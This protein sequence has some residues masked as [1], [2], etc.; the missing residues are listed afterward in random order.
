M[1]QFNLLVQRWIPVRRLSNKIDLIAP[2][3][4]VEGDDPPMRI[5]APRPD[6]DGALLQFLI[7][8]LQTVVA[9]KSRKEWADRYD[10]RFEPSVLRGCFEAFLQVFNLD[11]PGPRFMQD[12]DLKPEAAEESLIGSLLIDMPGEQG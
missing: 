2:W 9:P 1:Q 5:E 8:L 3:Q 10:S 6:F 12:L 7:G 11:G 4:I